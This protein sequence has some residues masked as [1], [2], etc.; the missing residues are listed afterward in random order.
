LSRK[1]AA[2]WTAGC[3]RRRITTRVLVKS[4]GLDL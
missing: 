2:I 3:H 1:A 4:A